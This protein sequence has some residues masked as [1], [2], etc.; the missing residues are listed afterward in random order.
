[1]AFSN[2]CRDWVAAMKAALLDLEVGKQLRVADSKEAVV[3]LDVSMFYFQQLEARVARKQTG[4]KF[5]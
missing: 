1:M 5:G 4:G 3:E 2:A